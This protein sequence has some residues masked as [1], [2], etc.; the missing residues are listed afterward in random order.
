[1]REVELF[2]RGTAQTLVPLFAKDE[3]LT[4]QSPV[5]EY[6]QLHTTLNTESEGSSH[7]LYFAKVTGEGMIASGIFP[8]DMLVVDQ[9]LEPEPGDIVVCELAGS[10]MLRAYYTKAG[11]A[12]LLADNNYF[13][14]VELDRGAN[15]R[16]WGVVPFSLIDQRRRKNA[17]IS[18]FEQFL[19]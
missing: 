8:D 2:K 19:R 16:I 5:S 3:K 6:E 15:C 13:K 11:R 7:E 14:P 12:Y 1:M 10:F 17:R 4:F 9:S 18:R